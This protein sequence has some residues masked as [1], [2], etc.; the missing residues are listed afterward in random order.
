MFPAQGQSDPNAKH[1]LRVEMRRPAAIHPLTHSL[2]HSLTH[3][4][5]HSFTYSPRIPPT[6]WAV[7]DPSLLF[8][9]L[10]H[11]NRDAQA[12]H[13]IG[14]RGVCSFSVAN[15]N[16][17]ANQCQCRPVSRCP[18]PRRTEPLDRP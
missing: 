11:L 15:A 9:A 13:A 5:T 2:P 1:L 17:N 3:S 12:G 6:V 7:R 4:P 14:R 10:V 8:P 16:A 18:R